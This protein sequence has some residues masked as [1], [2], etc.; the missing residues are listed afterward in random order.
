MGLSGN[1]DGGLQ[2]LNQTTNTFGGPLP[3][4]GAAVSENISVDA[5]RSLVLSL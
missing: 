1:S 4:T 2:V 3:L 5:T